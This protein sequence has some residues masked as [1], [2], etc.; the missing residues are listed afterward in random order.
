MTLVLKLH[1]D[2]VKITGHA[3]NLVSMSRHS[4]VIAQ[5]HTH[6]HTHRMKALLAHVRGR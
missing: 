4:R 1:L 5:T 3:K 2:M 6:T